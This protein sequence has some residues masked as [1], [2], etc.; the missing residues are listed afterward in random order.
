MVTFWT[1]R[2]MEAF[3]EFFSNF[4]YEEKNLDKKMIWFTAY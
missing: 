2:R 4:E 3:K 1:C